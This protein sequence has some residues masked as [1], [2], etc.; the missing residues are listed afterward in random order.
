MIYYNANK[1]GLK[2][3]QKQKF[4]LYLK[5]ITILIAGHKI[6]DLFFFHFRLTDN[7][8]LTKRYLYL[9]EYK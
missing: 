9:K 2:Q 3:K 5:K 7:L 8:E 4:H 6:Y 1:T